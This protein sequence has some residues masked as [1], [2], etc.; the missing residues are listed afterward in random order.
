MCISNRYPVKRL[1]QPIKMRSVN[2]IAT[3]LALSPDSYLAQW[4]GGIAI[5]VTLK[6]VTTSQLFE[7]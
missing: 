6:T 4:D 2:R 7:V 1:T 3:G 5:T